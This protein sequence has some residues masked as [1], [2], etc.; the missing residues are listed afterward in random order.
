MSVTITL[1]YAS[2][3]AL[4]FLSLSLRVVLL[5]RRHRVGIGTGGEQ[6]LE[7]AARAHANFAEYVPLALVLMLA[8][9]LWAGAPAV[10]LHL[11]GI[12]LVVGRT[13]H[14]LVG[15]NRS[16][17]QSPGRFIG[18]AL[19]WLVLLVSAVTGLVVVI[20]WWATA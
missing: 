10:L 2:L 7:L 3:L 16:A 13:L 9:E 6:S 11:L 20:G 14:G 15:L 1:F 19:T 18:T 5:R 17:G 4:L 12:A 8:L